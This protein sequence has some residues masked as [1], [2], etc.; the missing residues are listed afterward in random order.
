M[1]MDGR[2]WAEKKGQEGLAC[3]G[4]NGYPAAAVALRYFSEST[5]KRGDGSVEWVEGETVSPALQLL[6]RIWFPPTLP[7]LA[8]LRLV[9]QLCAYMASPVHQDLFSHALQRRQEVERSI[10]I[11]T[12]ATRTWQVGAVFYLCVE[13]ER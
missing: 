5:S 4:A 2:R 9:L 13:E 6:V 10:E 7:S 12:Q 1:E 8:S 3:G 11:I